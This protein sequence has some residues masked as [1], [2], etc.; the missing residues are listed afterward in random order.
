[1]R[2]FN[3]ALLG[4]CETRWTQSGRLR[5]TTGEIILYSGH[6]EDDAPHS[7]GVALLLGKE[8]QRALIGWEARGPSTVVEPY[9]PD[10]L[11]TLA[12][13]TQL[14]FD[15][16]V[17]GE[18]RDAM[19]A[20][21]ASMSQLDVY[22]VFLG[23]T[24]AV[25]WLC[26]VYRRRHYRISPVTLALQ[27]VAFVCLLQRLHAHECHLHASAVA[28]CVFLLVVVQGTICTRLCVLVEPAHY[29]ENLNAVVD[30]IRW[31]KTFG[32]KTGLY[33][34]DRLFLMGHSAGGH[35]ASCVALH[36]HSDRP[37]VVD[38]I[39]GVLSLSAVYDLPPLYDVFVTRHLFLLPTFGR[40]HRV[41]LE[42]S[43]VRQLASRRHQYVPPFLVVTAS[44]DCSLNDQADNFLSEYRR[45][46]DRDRGEISRHVIP[47][48]NHIDIIWKIKYHRLLQT[49][50]IGF[51]HS[52]VRR[53][54]AS[55]ETRHG[56]DATR[57]GAG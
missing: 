53:L 45:Y 12:E 6:E 46:N 26:I 9:L 51:I 48:T 32:E 18:L 24:Q 50:C 43:P 54:D 40:D 13:D 17:A 16:S 41:W 31:T 36:G 57:D 23:A 11:L 10:N 56:D 37:A 5:L 22:C 3:L 1:M 7:E 55:S 39:K 29:P 25:T 52:V 14:R 35:L 2:R 19:T 42:A 33:R 15:D 20:V 49:R 27:L 30:S 4:L 44:W 8:A 47:G 38:E 21:V 28:C 34:P